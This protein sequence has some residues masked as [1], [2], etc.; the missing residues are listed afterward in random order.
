MRIFR[1]HR[2]EAPKVDTAALAD[3]VHLLA[4]LDRVLA[5]LAAER[6]Y[7]ASAVAAAGI[8]WLATSGTTIDMGTAA[9][10]TLRRAGWLLQPA[11][12][13]AQAAAAAD[14]QRATQAEN[15]DIPD[16]W[17]Q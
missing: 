9:V 5:Y 2:D 3:R 10:E 14:A 8:A 12:R 1:Q 7:D 6:P 13:A 4:G 17:A 11:P 15:T 16:D